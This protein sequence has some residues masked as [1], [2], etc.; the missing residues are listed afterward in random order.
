MFYSHANFAL[1]KETL[2]IVSLRYYQL[3]RVGEDEKKWVKTCQVYFET[4]A[5]KTIIRYSNFIFMTDL[6]D[7]N[8]SKYFISLCYLTWHK[9]WSTVE[10][11]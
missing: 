8:L 1:F 2:L 6:S 3:G 9:N 10:A 11:A 5:M 4:L 7:I